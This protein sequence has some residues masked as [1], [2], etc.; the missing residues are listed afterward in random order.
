MVVDDRRNPCFREIGTLKGTRKNL[1]GVVR[2]AIVFV[3][4]EG[5]DDANG[6]G[7]EGESAVQT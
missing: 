5:G 7:I 6:T 3:L 4:G 1:P 2:A